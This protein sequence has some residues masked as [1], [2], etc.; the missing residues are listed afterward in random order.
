MQPGCRSI[1]GAC[2]V[3]G[4]E[5]ERII[6]IQRTVL[7]NQH[8]RLRMSGCRNSGTNPSF[9]SLQLQSDVVIE[10]KTRWV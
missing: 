4:N 7:G 6:R 3:R 2:R 9:H 1:E 10:E 5:C 8:A